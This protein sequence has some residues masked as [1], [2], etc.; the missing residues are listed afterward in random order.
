MA[1]DVELAQDVTLSPFVVSGEHFDLLVQGERR[2]RDAP[3]A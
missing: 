2:G 1:V 3:G